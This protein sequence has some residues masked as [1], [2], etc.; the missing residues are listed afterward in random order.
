LKK[1]ANYWIFKVKDDSNGRYTL[2]GFQIFNQRME[3]KAWG[4][5]EFTENGR[6]T[7][8]I[9]YLREDDKVLFYLCGKDGYCFIGAGVLETG[10]GKSLKSVFHEEYLDWKIGV[11]L[12]KVDPWATWLPI[13]KLRGKV[14]FV[15]E[16][17]NYGSYMQGSITRITEKDY[18]TIIKEHK[19]QP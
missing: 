2:T 18:N 17:K 13:E 3:D 6:K 5:K 9:A 10:F 11:L 8:N 19:L 16:G 15:P 4:I 14:H 1:L 7:A 12:K